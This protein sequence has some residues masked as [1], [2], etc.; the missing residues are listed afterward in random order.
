VSQQLK[1]WESPRRKGR[2]DKGRGGSARQRQLVKRQQQLRQRLKANEGEANDKGQ[3]KGRNGKDRGD[4]S[5]S[6]SFLP[7][8]SQKLAA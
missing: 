5:V 6:P 7:S 8:A 2:N 4:G 1:R 3:T